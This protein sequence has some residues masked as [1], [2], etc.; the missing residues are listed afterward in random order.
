MTGSLLAAGEEEE[1]D[2]EAS[3]EEHHYFAAGML[4]CK[5]LRSS[6]EVSVKLRA[7]RGRVC[8]MPWLMGTEPAA[9][10]QVPRSE[11]LYLHSLTQTLYTLGEPLSGP[12]EQETCSPMAFRTLVG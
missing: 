11:D 10:S 2:E 7:H 12:K 5:R 9:S 8:I 4:F 3:C 6:S 1:E